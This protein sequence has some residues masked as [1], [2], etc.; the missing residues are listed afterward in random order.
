VYDHS[1]PFEIG[2][3][4]YPY[5]AVNVV[6]RGGHRGRFCC[7]PDG[8]VSKSG[9]GLA[10]PT[11]AVN[12]AHPWSQLMHVSLLIVPFERLM[13]RKMGGVKDSFLLRVRYTSI[14]H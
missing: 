14:L 8:C 4:I 11:F 2:L 1:L 13:E 6:M 5:N 9:K 3:E 7:F 10:S 12:A